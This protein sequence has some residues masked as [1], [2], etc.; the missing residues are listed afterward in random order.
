MPMVHCPHCSLRQYAA[1]SHATSGQCVLCDGAM[2]VAPRMRIAVSTRG[3]DWGTP[4]A[5]GP[6]GEESRLPRPNAYDQRCHHI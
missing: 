4:D 5:N 2:I 6:A 1:A 3:G